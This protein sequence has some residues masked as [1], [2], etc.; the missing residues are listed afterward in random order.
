MLRFP[1]LRRGVTLLEI[2]VVL[3]IIAAMSVMAAGMFPGP[4]NY[5]RARRSMESMM[6][7][8][9]KV[10]Q[11]ARARGH[12]SNV[13]LAGVVGPMGPGMTQSTDPASFGIKVYRGTMT[14]N[15]AAWAPSPD[16]FSYI[17][18][19]PA[20]NPP[21][22]TLAAL[23]ALEAADVVNLD[24]ALIPVVQGGVPAVQR[25]LPINI[26]FTRDVISGAGDIVPNDLSTIGCAACPTNFMDF[27]LSNNDGYF[28]IQLENR[29]FIGMRYVPL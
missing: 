15:G 1:R 4:I 6:W 11:Q 26:T 13:G 23:T 21:P 22:D 19:G 18:F 24:P 5:F 7:A 28:R 14:W 12:S 2:L 17:A 8:M 25:G 9:R 10:Q 16:G 20:L 3:S 29:R 27:Q